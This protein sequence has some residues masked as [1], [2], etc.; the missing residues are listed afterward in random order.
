MSIILGICGLVACADIRKIRF[1]IKKTILL[2]KRLI[3]RMADF[4][5]TRNKCQEEK[6][7]LD[8]RRSTKGICAGAKCARQGK[9]E[10]QNSGA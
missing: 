7:S 8:K 6:K 3:R 9:V 5:I 1:L 10:K 2:D 4:A